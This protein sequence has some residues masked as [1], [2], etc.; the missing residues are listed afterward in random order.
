MKRV[1]KKTMKLPSMQSSADLLQLID[2]EIERMYE[3]Q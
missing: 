1:S 2:E 3:E